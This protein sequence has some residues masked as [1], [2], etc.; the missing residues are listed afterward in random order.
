MVSRCRRPHAAKDSKG[1]WQEFASAAPSSGVNHYYTIEQLS[2]RWSV[3]QRTANEYVRRHDFPAPLAFSGRTRRW[4]VDEVHAWETGHRDG[5][6]S[7]RSP[8]PAG[9]KAALTPIVVR[10]A[11]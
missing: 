11:A 1:E 3:A 10:S 5:R 7:R 4:P 2:E 6:R 9:R 8:R